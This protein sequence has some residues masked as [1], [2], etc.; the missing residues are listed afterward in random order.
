MESKA[1]LFGHSIHQQLIVVPLGSFVGAI[2]FDILFLA[3]GR[4]VWAETAYYLIA[5][6]VISGLIAALFG[7]IDWTAIPWGTRAKRVGL[8][9]AGSM[10]AA[11]VLFFISWMLRRHQI[12]AP[13][14]AAFVFSFAGIIV[15]ALGGWMGGELVDRLGVGVDSNANLD[16][17]SSLTH[18]A[19]Q[20][21]T[22]GDI[23]HA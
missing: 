18:S 1:K 15:G 22:T 17:P 13:S 21:T 8:F 2:I 6:G 16:A 10:V 3:R 23:R 9:H 14:M 12:S 7:V 20:P 4:S 19:T 5:L 11:V